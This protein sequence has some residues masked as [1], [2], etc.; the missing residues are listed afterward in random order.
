MRKLGLLLG[1]S[2]VL[3]LALAPASSAQEYS[4]QVVGGEADREPDVQWIAALSYW[5]RHAC[6]GSL[7]APR[8]VLTAAHCVNGTRVRGWRVRLGSKDRTRGGTLLRITGRAIYPGYRPRRAYGDM[9]LMRLKRPVGYTPVEMVPSGT[10]YVGEQGYIAG[11]G[12]TFASGS[13]PRFLRSALLPIRPDSV[14]A[15]RWDVYRGSVM[16]CAGDGYPSGC[17]GDSG[18][19]LARRVAGEWRLLGVTSFGAR[20][21]NGPNVHAWVG[22]PKLRSWLRRRL[23]R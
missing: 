22:S 3:G 14:C 11:W 16:I 8:Y 10:H 23:G 4:T 15:R 20:R 18:G 21:C 9:A 7:V 19:P 6:G 1:L 2:A 17:Y 13:S 5:R 12:R